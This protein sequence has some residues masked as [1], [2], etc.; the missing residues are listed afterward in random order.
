MKKYLILTVL[1]CSC[2]DAEWSKYTTL[3]QRAEIICRSGGKI[4]FH[5]VS[6]GKVMNEQNSDGYYAKWKIIAAPDYHHAKPGDIRTG[7]L[8]SD[9]NIIYIEDK[10]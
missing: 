10:D 9:C 3:G 1:F 2:T 5:G 6:T 8:A 7:T 4:S